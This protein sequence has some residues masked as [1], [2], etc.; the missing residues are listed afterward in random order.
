M[1]IS[2]KYNIIRNKEKVTGMSSSLH[3]AELNKDYRVYGKH[4]IECDYCTVCSKKI[5]CEDM[6]YSITFG[7]IHPNML[8]SEL[9]IDFICDSC[10][11]KNKINERLKKMGF[12]SDCCIICGKK[13]KDENNECSYN[14]VFRRNKKRYERFSKYFKHIVTCKTCWYNSMDNINYIK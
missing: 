13:T 10:S 9:F 4:I 3:V 11:K 8:I 6:A 12:M 1:K 2:I 14:I 5:I 7:Y